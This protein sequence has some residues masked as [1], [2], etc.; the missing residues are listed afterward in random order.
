MSGDKVAVVGAGSWGTAL[1]HL[2]ASKGVETVLWSFEADVAAA[3]N[4]QHRNPRYLNEIALDPRLRA[5][6]SLESA[7]SGARAVV[8]VSPSHVVRQ[9][10]TQASPYL[11]DDALVISASKGIEEQTLCT[12]DRVL[13]DVLPP[14]VAARAAF[15]SG[16]SFALE[17][18][19]EHPT[20][21]T[22]ASAVPAAAERAR[23]LFQTPKFRVYTHG[24]VAGVEL[25]GALKNVVAIAAGVVDGL[26]FGHN[27]RAAL[28]TRGLAE[29]TRLGVAL[30]AN[31]RTFAGLAGMGDLILTCTGGLSRNRS[32]GVELGK[33]RSLEEV[34]GGM[35][36]VAEGVRTTRSARDLAHRLGVEMPIVEAVHAVL[37]ENRSAAAA[38]E[39][40]MLRE[41]KS[42]HWA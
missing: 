6:T 29:M 13:A 23:D 32:V 18:A 12:M 4:E 24:D 41:P 31:A 26:G 25:G 30:G 21:V 15:L 40:L 3:I 16:P 38:V 27:T 39:E 17:V 11:A 8:S 14:A 28:I 2:L 42:E 33:G 37:F 7:V 1:A 5:S 34:L 9:V 20:A 22:M 36:M 19:R 10:M 35:V